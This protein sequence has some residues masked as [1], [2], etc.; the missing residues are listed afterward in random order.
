MLCK[1]FKFCTVENFLKVIILSHQQE[2]DYQ[3][4]LAKLQS[5]HRGSGQSKKER[6]TFRCLLNIRNIYKWS[7]TVNDAGKKDIPITFP[8]LRIHLRDSITLFLVTH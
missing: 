5:L 2:S 4:A 8:I 3:E 7:A 6:K 1:M